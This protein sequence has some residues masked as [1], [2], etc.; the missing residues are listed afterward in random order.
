MDERTQRVDVSSADELFENLI[1]LEARAYCVAL[2]KRKGLAIVVSDKYVAEAIGH[3]TEKG[4]QNVV[5]LLEG[6]VAPT[7]TVVSPQPLKMDALDVLLTSGDYNAAATKSV[8]LG[9]YLE[10]VGRAVK[11]DKDDVAQMLYRRLLSV[12][13][14]ER[15]KMLAP[16]ARV[17]MGSSGATKQVGSFSLGNSPELFEAQ[18]KYQEA[19]TGYVNLDRTDEAVVVAVKYGLPLLAYTLC[20]EKKKFGVAAVAALCQENTRKADLYKRLYQLTN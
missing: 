17:G 6:K 18:G 1:T 9:R 12:E 14:G 10:V 7:K 15:R 8:E 3:Y 4:R 19:I 16:Q 11:E 20:E 5:D 2:F 13:P